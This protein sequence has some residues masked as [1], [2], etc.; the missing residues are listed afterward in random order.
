MFRYFITRVLTITCA[1]LVLAV[2]PVF[3]QTSDKPPTKEALIRQAKAL[4]GFV[5]STMAK[6][7]LAAV[8]SLPAAPES[9]VAYRNRSTGDVLTETE[10]NSLPDSTLKAYERIEMDEEFYYLTN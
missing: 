10:A 4:K 5:E 7:F 2:A 6:R 3:A 8:H 9:R 1:I